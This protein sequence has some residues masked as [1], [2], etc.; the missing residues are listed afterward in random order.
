M[1]SR[2]RRLLAEFLGTF[3]LAAVVVGSGIAA[4]TLSPGQVGL[5]LSENAIATALGLGVIIV[6]DC[7]RFG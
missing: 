1:A 2:P 3:L 7:C 6:R 4:Q 5:E